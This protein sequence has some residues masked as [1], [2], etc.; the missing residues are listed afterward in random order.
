MEVV[1]LKKIPIKF[2]GVDNSQAVS[3]LMLCLWKIWF[4]LSGAELIY[5]L[6]LF[7]TNGE[8]DAPLECLKMLDELTHSIIYPITAMCITVQ[9]AISIFRRD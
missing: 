7:C 8:T 2:R 4:V 1:G 5:S 6:I 9:I 3:N